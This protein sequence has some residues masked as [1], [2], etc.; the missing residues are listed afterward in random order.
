M[1]TESEIRRMKQQVLH[2]INPDCECPH[3]E[4]AALLYALLGWILDEMPEETNDLTDAF[5]A[6]GGDGARC[7]ERLRQARNQGRN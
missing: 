7:H 4:Q 3:C 2:A 5:A 6:G 1:K